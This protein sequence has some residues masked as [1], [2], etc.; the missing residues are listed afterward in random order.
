MPQKIKIEGLTGV[1]GI[2]VLSSNSLILYI[3]IELKS[4]SGGGFDCL[5]KSLRI[6]ISAH[7]CPFPFS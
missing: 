5:S 6:P 1:P 4:F 2:T 7:V 3:N